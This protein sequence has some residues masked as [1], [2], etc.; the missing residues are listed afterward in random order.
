MQNST[1]RRPLVSIVLCLLFTTSLRAQ[2]FLNHV[3][4]G[5]GAGFSFPVS[6]LSHRT[7]TGFNFVASGGPRF[8]SRFSVPIDFSLHYL[9]IKNSAR[10]T[11]PNIDLFLGSLARIWSLTVNPSYE[12]I[13]QERFGSYATAGYGLYNRKL[14]LAAPGLAPVAAC[15]PFWNVC[16]NNL[17]SGAEVNGELGVYKGG[18]NVGGGVTFGAHTKFF[19]E[20]RYHHMLT[21]QAELVPLTFGI[22]W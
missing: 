14:L 5:A 13:K 3:T 18:Y 2:N 1:L 11:D 22:R 20:I 9:N 21:T 16:V 19:A 10:S 15:D 7:K 4:M 8:N 17:P 6:T 12:F